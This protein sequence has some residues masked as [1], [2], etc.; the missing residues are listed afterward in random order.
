MK[1]SPAKFSINLPR[2]WVRLFVLLLLA[3]AAG[4]YSYFKL[5]A[6]SAKLSSAL[7][8]TSAALEIPV[9]QWT[10]PNA[11]PSPLP[12]G[13]SLVRDDGGA[14]AAVFLCFGEA[15]MTNVSR[16][17]T[18]LFAN[19]PT[20][21]QL[22][23]ACTDASSLEL[24]ENE[25]GKT[26]RSKGREVILLNA[27]RPLT[28]WARDRHLA[29]QGPL[30][31]LRVS[32]VPRPADGAKIYIHERALPKIRL[33]NGLIDRLGYLPFFLEGG[34]V[35]SNGRH[36]FIGNNVL[37]HNEEILADS[38]HLLQE[39]GSLFGREVLLVRDYAGKVP[40]EHVDMYLT[41]I[42]D[43]NV[44]LA[45]FEEGARLLEAQ[46]GRKPLS[47]VNVHKIKQRQL[48]EISQIL[49]QEG[50]TVHRIPAVIH[51]QDEWMVTYNNGLMERRNGEKIVY[52][53]KYQLP[54]L[55]KAAAAVYTRLGFRVVPIDVSQVFRGRGA[56]RCV[57]NVTLRKP[58]PAP[59]T[60]SLR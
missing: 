18:D 56:L 40:H 52:L 44:L 58:L 14:I 54:V 13:T 3:F 17:F 59:A 31:K 33:D 9:T 1:R 12:A 4:H 26:E 38:N 27:N 24:F 57:T 39:L 45:D 42:D 19:L 8:P 25:W 10:P 16:L 34:N 35:T 2:N 47:A 49:R 53:P 50:Y 5:R 15:W 22:Q 20:D 46:D 48:K 28:V 21:V 23:V 55:D 30:G 7:N 6:A 51:S 60:T 32:L 43:K 29:A 41:P 36:V 11:E 37:E